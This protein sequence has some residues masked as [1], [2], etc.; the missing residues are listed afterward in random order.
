MKH[1]MH[2]DK[3]PFEKIK[4]GIKKYEFRLFDD[5]RKQLCI[6][7]D[8]E[9]ISTENES[10]RLV[11]HVKELYVADDFGQVYDFFS[12]EEYFK[13]YTKDDFLQGMSSIYTKEQQDK[14]GVLVIEI[15]CV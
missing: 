5:K 15:L 12:D 4:N 8:I 14:Y 9:F 3:R 2:L 7:D 11:C 6:D 13:D 1:I 10:D